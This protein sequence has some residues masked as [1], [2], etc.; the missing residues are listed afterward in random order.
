MDPPRGAWAIV[1]V[2]AILLTLSMA[3]L[4]VLGAPPP[5]APGEGVP[6]FGHVFLIIGEN[7]EVSQLTPK[8]SPY[9][10]DVLKPASA[11]LTEYYAVTHHSLA[12][13]VAMTSGQYTSCERTDGRPAD[14]HQDVDNLFK[15]LDEAGMSW[16]VWMESMPA[17]CTLTNAGS[18]SA[19]NAYDA[20][21][22][23]AIFYDDIEG[24]RGLWSPTSV[25]PECVANV[26][27]A[28][29]TDANNMSAFEG[30]LANGRVGRFNLIVPNVCEDGHSICPPS[31]GRIG[32]FDA[33][34]AREVPH[35]LAS[36]AFGPD[37]LLII[38]FDEGTTGHFTLVDRSGRGGHIPCLIV[39][40]LLQAGT[41]GGPADDYG[42]LRMLED[43]FRLPSYLGDAARTT[44]ISVTWIR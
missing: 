3:E 20:A 17:P 38:T 10:L 4:T 5:T 28:G 27:P 7:T 21:H 30:A 42:L 19:F 15:Q 33:F 2:V 44:P 12:D 16:R 39:S 35:I 23:P 18:L 31:K 9:L 8:N 1:A 6:A 36:P 26:L 22:N 29:G 32:Q 24:A 34:L 40:P 37:G 11:W 13:Y 25:S 41:Y 14:C 43:G